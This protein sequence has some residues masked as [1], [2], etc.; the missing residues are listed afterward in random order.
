M[1]YISALEAS[2]KWGVSLRQVQRLLADNRIP[3]AQKYGRSWTIPH[4]AGKPI[5]LRRE[6]KLQGQPLS[7]DLS[8]V[9]AATTIPM[10]SHN[11]DAILGTMDGDRLRVA[12][13]AEL[14]YLRGDFQRVIQYYYKTEGDDAVRLR[15]RRPS[16]WEITAYIPR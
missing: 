5:D 1:E 16:A 13:E 9:I 11:P 14:A 15:V 2:K 6:K 3:R 12:Y 4:D 10:P 7:A 8:H